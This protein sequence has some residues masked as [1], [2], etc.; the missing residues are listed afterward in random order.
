MDQ[1]ILGL[2]SL[3]PGHENT[4][5]LRTVV[6]KRCP[7]IFKLGWVSS[8]INNESAVAD[9]YGLPFGDEYTIENGFDQVVQRCVSGGLSQCIHI[10]LREVKSPIG[11]IR[12]L[13]VDRGNLVD[14]EHALSRACGS[15]GRTARV[16]VKYVAVGRLLVMDCH[17]I[18][19]TGAQTEKPYKSE[20]Q[21]DELP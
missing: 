6:M 21:F 5:A 11:C 19:T 18:I 16:L 14:H 7:S 9:R 3:V 10:N 1:E 17:Q 4:F 8:N 12:I 20:C 2:G 13:V 15:M